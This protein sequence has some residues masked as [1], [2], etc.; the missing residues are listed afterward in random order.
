MN[1][2]TS[3]ELDMLRAFYDES[4]DCC[5]QCN[6]QENMS[7]MNANDLRAVLGGS[8]QSIGGTMSSL[9]EKGAICDT[10]ESSRGLR[11]TDWHID[12]ALAERLF[13][14]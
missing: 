1:E 14:N 13:S 6:E 10:G 2:F 9:Q 3:N 4:I 8:K 12:S 5:G 11:I 7:Y